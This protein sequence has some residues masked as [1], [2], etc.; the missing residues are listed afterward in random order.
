MNNP[1]FV[2]LKNGVESQAEKLGYKVIV[3]D[4]QD[5]SSKQLQMLGLNNK[6]VDVII[7]N[8]TDSMVGA[9]VKAANKANIPVIT[10]TEVNEVKLL[11]I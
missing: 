10:V 1:F 3:Y 4:A 8:P 2:D 11:L 6:K 9:A 7:I 5:D